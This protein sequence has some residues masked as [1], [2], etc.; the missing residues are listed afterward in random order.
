MGYIL[1]CGFL[2][3]ALFVSE[4][5]IDTK[6][7]YVFKLIIHLKIPNIIVTFGRL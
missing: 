1:Y 6:N 5:N 2:S 3:S 7:F 4:K